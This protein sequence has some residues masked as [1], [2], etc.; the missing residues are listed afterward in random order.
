MTEFRS[1]HFVPSVNPNSMTPLSYSFLDRQPSDVGVKYYRLRQID[2]D[3]K[4]TYSPVVAVR[5][6]AARLTASVY[7]NP[8]SQQ[9]Q[10]QITGMPAT[11]ARLT[12]HN[13]LG[14]EVLTQHYT[15]AGAANTFALT[16]PAI[17]PPGTYL[18]QIEIAGQV[19]HERLIRE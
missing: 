17:L 9:V 7:P 19:F 2:L 11:P 1:L 14:Q 18:L 8:F 12:L 6:Q 10:V 4:A 3:G 16:P 13:T 15:T 5:S